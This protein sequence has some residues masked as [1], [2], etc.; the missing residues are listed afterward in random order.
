VTAINDLLEISTEISVERNCRAVGFGQ[1]NRFRE[2]TAWMYLRGTQH[3]HGPSAIFDDNFR[4]SA[5]V[6]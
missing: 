1:C 4:A 5:H 6:N 3:G 2:E